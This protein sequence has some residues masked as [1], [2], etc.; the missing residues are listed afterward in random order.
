VKTTRRLA[1]F[2][3]RTALPVLRGFSRSAKQDSEANAVSG[4]A[5]KA[6]CKAS[7]NL[8]TED[9]RKISAKTRS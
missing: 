8:L 5:P 6:R 3:R 9:R 7:P 1:C 4:E 2:F